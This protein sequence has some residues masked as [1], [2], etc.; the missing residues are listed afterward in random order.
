MMWYNRL[1]DDL[2]I[3]KSKVQVIG[4]FCNKL[5]P[6]HAGFPASQI[7]QAILNPLRHVII[8]TVVTDIFTTQ[9]EGA[10]HLPE[11]IDA[12]HLP[13]QGLTDDLH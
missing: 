6:L 9:I 13:Y 5:G 8:T 2:W 1:S 7:R 11:S 4:L 12:T 3:T 10:V